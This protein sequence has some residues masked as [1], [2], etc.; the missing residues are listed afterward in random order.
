VQSYL[1]HLLGPSGVDFK[2]LRQQLK[3]QSDVTIRRA[4]LLSLG[5]F[6]QEDIADEDRDALVNDLRE[7]Y[8]DH[9][10]A[11]LHGAVE[12]LLRKWKQEEGLKEDDKWAKQKRRREERLELIRKGLAMGGPGQ[13]VPQ[14]YVNSQGQTMVVIP[15]SMEFMMGSPLKEVERYS[16]DEL[17][18]RPQRI[19]HHFAIASKPVTV[20]QFQL[21]LKNHNPLDSRPDCPVT[22]LSAYTAAA[23]CN[24]LSDREELERCYELSE[25]GKSEARIKPAP[26]FF[27]RTG[28]RLPTEEEWECCCRAGTVTSRYYGESVELLRKYAW[29]VENSGRRSSGVASLK[30]NDWGLFDM[31]G[32]VWS[33]CHNKDDGGK[34]EYRF[35]RG[36]S[37]VDAAR[38]IR[39]AC[40]HRTDSARPNAYLGVRL[41]RT[42]R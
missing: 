36:G 11:G 32:N 17:L 21:F 10:D 30:P 6:W 25:E 5:E 13:P 18:Q 39:A 33:W 35:F 42:L 34:T 12:W 41:A 14:W 37:Y 3:A 27:N 31:H 19:D 38:E 7:W 1:I 15:R 4:L 40:R 20:E 22:E 28:Y 26:D 9:R 16:V 24:W 23:Y 8:G 2:I 29:Y